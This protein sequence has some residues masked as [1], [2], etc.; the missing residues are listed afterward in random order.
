[1]TEAEQN[2]LEQKRLKNIEQQRRRRHAKKD[3]EEYQN[4]LRKQYEQRRQHPE[5]VESRRLYAREKAKQYKEEGRVCPNRY[6][7]KLEK[8]GAEKM[9]VYAQTY[10]KHKCETASNFRAKMNE[11]KKW[12]YRERKIKECGERNPIYAGQTR[13]T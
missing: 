12:T 13:K 6:S 9:R 2:T 4:K 7:I 1:M 5:W 11:I 10:Y 3:D 8:Y